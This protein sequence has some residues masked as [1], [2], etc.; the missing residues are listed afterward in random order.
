MRF[1]IFCSGIFFHPNWGQSTNAPFYNE[2]WKDDF[3]DTETF[4]GMEF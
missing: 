2:Y 1:M 4:E 3:K